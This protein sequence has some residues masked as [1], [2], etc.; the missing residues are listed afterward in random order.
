MS[1]VTWLIIFVIAFFLIITFKAFRIL[2]VVVIGIVY[3]PLNNLYMR[4]Q[5]WYF[6][7]K[8]KDEV[9]Y[10]AF[11]PFYWLLVGLTYIVSAPYEF[12]CNLG[13]H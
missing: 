9:V 5:K 3:M 10:Y 7:M 8:K 12:I 2:L 6:G 13:V 1:F 4:T 11:T